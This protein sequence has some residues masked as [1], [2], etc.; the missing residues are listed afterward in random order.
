MTW[1]AVHRT[2]AA[3]LVRLGME[4]APAGTRLHAVAEESVTTKE[5]AEAVGRS[6][7]LPVVSVAPE[8]A[9]LA[10]ERYCENS[11]RAAAESMS[12]SS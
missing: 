4:Q 3:R 2:D 9:G 6:L 11:S 5:I 7:G 10:L 8:D 1:S 12:S